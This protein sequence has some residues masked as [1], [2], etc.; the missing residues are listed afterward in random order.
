MAGGAWRVEARHTHHV[1]EVMQ[2]LHESSDADSH[3][4]LLSTCDQPA[5]VPPGLPK[6]S[7]D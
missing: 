1:L 4:T 6:G 2:G 3:I 7:F 5:L